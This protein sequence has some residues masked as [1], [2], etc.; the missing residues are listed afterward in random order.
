MPRFL[1]TGVALAVMFSVSS[2]PAD[3]TSPRPAKERAESDDLAP[4]A[5][6]RALA[7]GAAIVPGVI[8]HGA[9]HY[10]L[11]DSSTAGKLLLAEGIGLGMVT[12]GGTGLFLTGASRYT[13]GP[14]A[15]ISMFGVGVFSVAFIA[16][17]Y[18]VATSDQGSATTRRG[19][20]P[21]RFES[22]LGYRYLYT[23][24]FAYRDFVVER[25]TFWIAH[26]RVTP[27]ALFSFAGD[28]VRYR[29]ELAQRVLGPGVGERAPYEDRLEIEIAGTHHRYLP[30]GF[31]RT[32][33]ELAV[34]GRWD[35]GHIGPSLRGAF[36][37]GKP[38]VRVQ[39]DRVR[40][41]RRRS[42]RRPGRSFARHDGVRRALAWLHRTR[43]RG[44]RLLR[45][46][47]RRSGRRLH[48]ARAR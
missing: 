41:S 43:Q 31:Q 45:S 5:G 22:E 24:A 39:R 7:T 20:G 2:A 30:E 21:T 16:D 3:E 14:L 9:G 40:L 34:R 42:R 28:N 15:A 27:W 1:R 32:S 23:P 13:V 38:R 44:A 19:L 12:V 8:V 11:G 35:L 29:L 6:D 4:H 48:H 37:E 33:G 18:G 10:V 47:S 17:V 36:V 46:P 25:F 26:T